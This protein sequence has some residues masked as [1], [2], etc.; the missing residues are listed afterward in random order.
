VIVNASTT[1]YKVEQQRRTLM[2]TKVEK[3]PNLSLVAVEL[4][5]E[6]FDQRQLIEGDKIDFLEVLKAETSILSDMEDQG[7]VEYQLRKRLLA[8]KSTYRKGDK[9]EE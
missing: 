6:I 3:K 7:K 8:L 9:K 2:E 5:N 1:K 4:L